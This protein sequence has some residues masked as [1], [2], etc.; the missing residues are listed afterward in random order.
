MVS[1]SSASRAASTVAARSSASSDGSGGSDMDTDEGGVAGGDG[2]CGPKPMNAGAHRA[3]T[4]PLPPCDSAGAKQERG[5]V[6]ET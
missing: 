6:T 2:W 5:R 1:S 4:P 3:G